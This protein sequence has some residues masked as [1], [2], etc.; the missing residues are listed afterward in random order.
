M[1]TATALLTVTVALFAAACGSSAPTVCGDAIP[2]QQV[3]VGE[4]KQ[5]TPCFE[6]PGGG[7]LTLTQNSS[8]VEVV[9]AFLVG[10]NVGFTGISVGEATI[11]V[12]ATNE[13]K[14]SADLSFSVL[15]PNR[16]PEWTST[17]T[18]ATVLVNRS[19][20]WNLADMFT[21]PDGEEMTFSATS[22]NSGAAGVSVN[23]SIAEVSG[24]SG[25]E[26]RITLTAADP[27]G[28]E[29][30]GTVDVTVKTPVT[31]LEDDF[32]DE[33]TLD[34]WTH[35]DP[36]SMDASIEG[37][38]LRVRYIPEDFISWVTQE[39]DEATDWTM[40]ITMMPF[41]GGFTGT[42]WATGV[43]GGISAYLFFTGTFTEDRN[44]L[45]YNFE[46]GYSIIAGGNSSLIELDEFAKY[47][48]SMNGDN[49]LV[50]KGAGEVVNETIDGLVP[51]MV[52]VGLSG[53]NVASEYEDVA[54]FGVLNSTPNADAPKIARPIVP[55]TIALPEL[56]LPVKR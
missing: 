7:A 46:G 19:I 27:Q 24:L 16:G 48:I 29:G 54:V 47:S 11:T 2:Q 3:L 44:W 25:G 31:L 6:D 22:S 49:F 14:L 32:E 1:R 12:T 37:G 20:Q 40:E 52:A 28:E 38:V 51:T 33:A 21:E 56:K 30:S 53:A 17:M 10:S 9:Q 36:D 5:V 34:D 4:R 42:F 18:E 26:T 41:E 43:E 55:R 23:G 35:P 8:N 15:V 13:D 39:V 45:L 50:R